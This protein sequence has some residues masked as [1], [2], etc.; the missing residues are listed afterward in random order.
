M[1]RRYNGE[2]TIYRTGG[3]WIAEITIGYNPDTGKRISRKRT[4]PTRHEAA[5][6]LDELK[7][8]YTGQELNLDGEKITFGQWLTKWFEIYKKPRLRE[9]TAH[10]YKRILR[11]A[12]SEIGGV[13]L[14]R[15]TP[16]DLQGVIFGR[17][18]A[19]YRTA[20]LFRVLM[21]SALGAAVDNRLIR[22]NP[23]ARLELPA[24]PEKRP[25]VKPS[26]AD[27]QALLDEETCLP[28]WRQLILLE[29]VTGAR[30]SELLALRWEDLTQ[31]QGGGRVEIS[32]ALILGDNSRAGE[33]RPLIRAATKTASGKRTLAIP[34]S[35]V[36]E[37]KQLKKAQAAHRLAF[38]GA[39]EDSGYIFQTGLG[40]PIN[41]GTF[42]SLFSRV[43]KKLGIDC[44]FH[45]LRHDFASRMKGSGLFDLKDIQTQLGHSTI[46]VT[47]DIYTH[48]DDRQKHQVSDWTAATVDQLRRV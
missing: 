34:A 31:T 18:G 19:H 45:M 5:R 7:E 10:D 44:T 28:C 40:A 32:H 46:Q 42:N 13:K 33:R 16:A 2:G 8:H 38:P 41:P 47:M 36:N 25:F 24:P 37:L 11:L 12:W 39:I 14:S 21:K 1:A 29:F 9:N 30:I 27:W 48:L 22:E 43:R 17:L 4:A 23:A 20:K 3:R 26:L 6:L 15:L 35:I